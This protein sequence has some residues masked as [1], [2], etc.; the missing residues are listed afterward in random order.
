MKAKIL[1][2]VK[3]SAQCAIKE[4]IKKKTI[5]HKSQARGRG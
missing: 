3:E 4:L 1:C 5:G 2:K